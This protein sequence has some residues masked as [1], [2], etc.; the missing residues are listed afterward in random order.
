[1]YF[2]KQHGSNGDD[3]MLPAIFL[4]LLRLLCAVANL[5]NGY[6]RSEYTVYCPSLGKQDQNYE[7]YLHCGSLSRAESVR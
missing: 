2:L 3:A 6:V 1:M 5:W 4:G 7:N